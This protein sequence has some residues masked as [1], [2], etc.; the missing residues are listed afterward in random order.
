[1]SLAELKI[2]R[3]VLFAIDELEDIE[4]PIFGNEKNKPKTPID[5]PSA[6]TYE[7]HYKSVG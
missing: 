6:V 7:G 5:R 2:L 1:M 4:I 3:E